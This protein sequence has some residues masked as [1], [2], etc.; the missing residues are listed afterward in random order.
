MLKVKNLK[1]RIL[2]IAA[3]LAPLGFALPIGASQALDSR[4]LLPLL[5][6]SNWQTHTSS[7]GKFRVQ[8]PGTPEEERNSQNVGEETL[9]VE[10]IKFEDENGEDLMWFNTGMSGTLLVLRGSF[11]FGD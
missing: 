8:I 2:A 5:S 4:S 6:Q 7:T 11:S 9:S 1:L 10:E 3:V